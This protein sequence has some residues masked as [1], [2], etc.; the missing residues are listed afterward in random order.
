MAQLEASH[1]LGDF[2]VRN[3]V[4]SEAQLS[5]ALEHQRR[6]SQNLEILSRAELLLGEDELA[7]LHAR[8]QVN[9]ETI[10][11]AIRS[12]ELLSQD[13]LAEI[14]GPNLDFRIPLGLILEK[15]G[16]VR[17]ANLK[18][19]LG[20][21]EKQNFDQSKLEAYNQRPLSLAKEVEQ[22]TPQE[23][24]FTKKDVKMCRKC[25]ETQ[26]GYF[27]KDGL[28]CISH[29]DYQTATDDGVKDYTDKIITNSDLQYIMNNVCR[30]PQPVNKDLA[31]GAVDFVPL[32]NPF[33]TEAC[34]ATWDN[35]S[36]IVGNGNP[37]YFLNWPEW[38]ADTTDYDKNRFQFF[39]EV[40][41]PS[42][43]PEAD[44]IPYTLLEVGYFLLPVSDYG[45]TGL[46]CMGLQELRCWVRDNQTGQ[47]YFGS[48]VVNASV[49]C[50]DQG[51]CFN[52]FVFND[53]DYG[54]Y[55]SGFLNV[56]DSPW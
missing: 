44:S 51:D 47:W 9:E 29:Y 40:K 1:M 10:E 48:Q 14:T 7:L 23:K 8:L 50:N 39:W 11:S 15:L 30:G 25:M 49:L 28:F 13:E 3:R 37:N 46:V 41:T 18:T 35:L 12:L 2:L 20:R 42:D 22:A 56:S 43:W 53:L 55:Q 31:E 34:N 21:F 27:A 26:V 32:A 17:R 19:W 6:V 24:C 38:T 33:I 45:N 36:A 4:F 16:I 54:S 5:R 52:D